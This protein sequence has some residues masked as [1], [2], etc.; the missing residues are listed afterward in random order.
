MLGNGFSGW[1]A[2]II[3]VVVVLLF[4][5]KKLPGL[6]RSLAQSMKI[7]KSEVKSDTGKGVKS[8]TDRDD[9]SGTDAGDTPFSKTP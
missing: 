8:G 2:L 5:A 7:F 4:G 6:A 1:H 9:E 3:L